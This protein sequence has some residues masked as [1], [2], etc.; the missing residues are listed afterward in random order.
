MCVCL[1]V[2][3]FFPIVIFSWNIGGESE[4]GGPTGCSLLFETEGGR[5]FSAWGTEDGIRTSYVGH[6]QGGTE[7]GGIGKGRRG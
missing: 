4:V 5:S 2:N 7:R 1:K 6:I 3:Q